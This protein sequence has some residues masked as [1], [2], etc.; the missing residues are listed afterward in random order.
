VVVIQNVTD[1]IIASAAVFGLVPLGVKTIHDMIK[2]RRRKKLSEQWTT[3]AASVVASHLAPPVL[4][5]LL[6]RLNAMAESLPAPLKALIE[7]VPQQS[8]SAP[9]AQSSAP[10]PEA[11]ANGQAPSSSAEAGVPPQ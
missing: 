2:N 5:E 10:S 6:T 8:A 9:E 4:T 11:S 3:I 1:I 7:G